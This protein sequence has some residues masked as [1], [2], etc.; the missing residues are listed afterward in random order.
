LSV[1]AFTLATAFARGHGP[2]L[3]WYARN[4]LWLPSIRVFP[5]RFRIYLGKASPNSQI[6][7]RV[8]FLDSHRLRQ[9]FDPV[10]PAPQK[11]E[12]RLFDRRRFFP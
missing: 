4:Q 1:W 11:A 7:L 8:L 6:L 2:S 10:F 12:H 3:P 9:S 5:A